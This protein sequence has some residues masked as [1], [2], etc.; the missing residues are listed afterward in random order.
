MGGKIDEPRVGEEGEAFAE[1]FEHG[2]ASDGWL[3]VDGGVIAV[4]KVGVEVFLRQMSLEDARCSVG[5]DLLKLGDDGWGNVVASESGDDGRH[6]AIGGHVRAA[7]ITESRRNV[8][9]IM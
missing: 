6:V 8:T 1:V 7:D 5:V 3:F 2:F 4:A 9:F